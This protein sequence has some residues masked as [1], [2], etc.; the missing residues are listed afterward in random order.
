[1]KKL[2]RTKIDRIVC[3]TFRLI[4][5]MPIVPKRKVGCKRFYTLINDRIRKIRYKK[6]N[7]KV[8][9]K[10]K[11]IRYTITEIENTV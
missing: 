7:Y 1:M 8:L 9:Y 11:Y 4:L 3:P 10:I 6:N 2:R 5:R